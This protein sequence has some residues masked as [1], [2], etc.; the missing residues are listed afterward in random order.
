MKRFSVEKSEWLP[1]W[2]VSDHFIGERVVSFGTRTAAR[3][4]ARALNEAERMDRRTVAKSATVW[5]KGK[6]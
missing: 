5:Q 1:C 3:Y 2:W 4:A 6:R